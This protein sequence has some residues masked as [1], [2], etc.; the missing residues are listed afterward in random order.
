MNETPATCPECDGLGWV[1]SGACGT[2]IWCVAGHRTQVQSVES[3]R[4]RLSL[5][6]AIKDR[7]AIQG[8]TQDAQNDYRDRLDI[9]REHARHQWALTRAA[10]GLEP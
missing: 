8:M 7:V 4:A 3:K 6:C 1:V 5:V 2:W 9:L 10:F